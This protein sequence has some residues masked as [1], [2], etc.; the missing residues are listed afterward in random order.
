VYTLE[1]SFTHVPENPHHSYE[2]KECLCWNERNQEI[3]D[4]F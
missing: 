2:L 4:C 1:G 3:C